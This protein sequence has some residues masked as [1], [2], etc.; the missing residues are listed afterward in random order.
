MKIKYEVKK[1]KDIK[2][3]IVCSVT[4]EDQV[5]T[6]MHWLNTLFKGTLDTLIETNDFK[7]KASSSILTYL[8]PD[9]RSKRL[10][11]IGLGNSKEVTLETIR[12]SYA[13]AAKRLNGL[14][15]TSVGFEV[16]DLAYIKSKQRLTAHDR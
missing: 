6:K 11:V 15:L 14:K 2:A 16:P 5:S 12:K 1:I 8:G 13:A 10:L 7:G 3:E 4:F 9:N